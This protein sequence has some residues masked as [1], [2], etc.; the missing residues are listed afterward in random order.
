MA[1]SLERFTATG[2][3]VSLPGIRGGE[4]TMF[5]VTRRTHLTTTD[6]L[7]RRIALMRSH[8]PIF[9]RP[10]MCIRFATL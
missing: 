1:S 6:Q 2:G 8:F 10:A 5:D 7:A 4:D 9:D 3:D